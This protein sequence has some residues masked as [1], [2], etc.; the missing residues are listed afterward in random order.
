MERGELQEVVDVN[1]YT[2]PGFSRFKDWPMEIPSFAHLS[3]D[4]SR[5]VFSTCEYRT[6]SDAYF[7]GD[8]GYELAMINIDGTGKER[9]TR[10][11]RFDNYPV[12]SPDGTQ[13]AFLSSEKSRRPDGNQ[14][15]VMNEGDKWNKA[16]A[17]VVAH[18]VNTF[19]PVWSPDGRRLAFRMYGENYGIELVDIIHTAK[20]DGSELHRIGEATTLPTWSPNGEMLAFGKSDE[21]TATIYTARFD[22]TDLREIW[23]SGLEEMEE[24]ILSVDWSPDGTEILVVSGK[25]SGRG[26]Q[27]WTLSPDGKRLRRLGSSE[28]WIWQIWFDYAVWSPDGSRIAAYGVRG[29]DYTISPKVWTLARDGTDLRPE[30]ATAS[31]SEDSILILP[32]LPYAVRATRT[33]EQVDPAACNAG[34][35]VPNP[36]DNPGLVQDCK[37]LLGMRDTLAG[38]ATLN[39]DPDLSILEWEGLEIEGTPTRVQALDLRQRGLT[40]IIPPELGQLTEMR[41]INLNNR[42]VLPSDMLTFNIL[43]G[44][45]PPDLGNLSKLEVLS[46][47]GNF[48]SGSITQELG[49]LEHLQKLYVEGNFWSRCIPESLKGIRETDFEDTGLKFCSEVEA[50]AKDGRRI[51]ST[52]PNG[53]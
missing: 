29:L 26:T 49:R 45:I 43:T 13:I 15:L 52:A 46:L 36:E 30:V 18:G 8:F 42:T 40:G 4:G 25:R 39:W 38:R 11:R 14:L 2:E 19:P 53:S 21:E 41:R 20:A 37:V 10:D 6:H 44:Y 3:P 28:S 32:G 50:E 23:N 34:L 16:K 7:L 12:W 22:G 9:L 35:A 5:V 31:W 1:P 27:I 48:L 51:E 24:G 47:V 33:I 17:T